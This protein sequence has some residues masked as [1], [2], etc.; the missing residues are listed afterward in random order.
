MPP[1]HELLESIYHAGAQPHL[2]P[3]TLHGIAMRFGAAGANLI[4]K[5]VSGLTM[6]STEGVAEVT[7]QFDAAGL[8][9]DNSRV[10]RLMDR[11]PHP[12]FLT[13]SHLHSA[14]ELRELPLY[15]DFLNPRGAAAGA[16]SVIQGSMDDVLVVAFEA[17]PSHKHSRRAVVPLNRLRPHLARALSL[18][19]QIEMARLHSILEAFEACA[20]A[21]ALLDEHGGVVGANELFQARTEGLARPDRA[22]LAFQDVRARQRF[23]EFLQTHGRQGLGTSLALRDKT[24][25]GAAVLHIVPAR[26]DDANVF[27]RVAYYAVMAKPDNELLPCSDIIA[28]LFDLTPAEARVARAV[29]KGQSPGAVAGELKISAETVRSHLKRVFSKTGVSRQSELAALLTRFR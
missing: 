4:R 10:S 18:G 15:R 21:V 13:D 7:Q 8:N 2:W 23:Q 24:K 29:A 26:R 3:A 6:I 17:F 19:S 22:G 1:T 11:H 5:S 14:R 28:A 12:G 9:E 27:G 25:F 16:A 20:T